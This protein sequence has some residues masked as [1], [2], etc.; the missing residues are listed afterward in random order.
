M[1]FN[2]FIAVISVY[3]KLHAHCSHK[4]DHMNNPYDLILKYCYIMTKMALAEVHNEVQVKRV[5]KPP[6]LMDI[7]LREKVSPF[8]CVDGRVF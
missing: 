2:V 6:L 5:L 3:E 4:A 7:T 8:S 1:F